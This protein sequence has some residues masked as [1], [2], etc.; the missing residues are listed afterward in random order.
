MSS[1]SVPAT[2]SSKVAATEWNLAVRCKRTEAGGGWRK[3][4]EQGSRSRQMSHSKSFWY[5]NETGTR[6]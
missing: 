1:S 4:R 6:Q 5:N 3:D 2:M